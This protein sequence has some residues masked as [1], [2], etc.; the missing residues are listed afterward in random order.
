MNRI[1]RENGS[2]A[3]GDVAMTATTRPK[4]VGKP[5]QRLEDPRLLAGTG[6]YTADIK[7]DRMVHAA[8]LRS[9]NAH[10]RIV[11]IDCEA[12]RAMPGVIGVHTAADFSEI[13]ALTAPSRMRDYH[14]TSCTVLAREKVRYVG[15]P[16]AVVVARD[17]YVAEDALGLIEVEWEPLDVAAD[18]RDAVR[19]DAP[20]LHEELGTN[21]LFERTFADGEPDAAMARAAHTVSARFRMHRKS[22]LAMEPRAY[23][24]APD[25]ASGGLTLYGS[26][27]V[28]G[29]VRDCLAS[30]LGMAGS[31]LRVI[32]PDVGGGFGGK[33]SVYPE[34]IAVCALARRLDRPV[35]WVSDRGEDLASTSQGFDEI[36]EAELGFGDDGALVALRADVIGDVGAYSI[37]PWTAALEP[38]Q[39]VSFLPGPY[40]LGNYRGRVRGVATP[41]PPTGPYRGVGR[42]ASTFVMERLIDMAAGKLGMDPVEMRRRNLV[43]EE[44]F[45]YRAGSGIVWERSGFIECLDEACRS[46][47]YEALRRRQR[48]ARAQGRWFGI[49]IATYAELTGIG[50]RISVAPGMPINTGTETATVRIDSTG[51]VT[52]TFAVASHGQSLETTLAQVVAEELGVKPRDVRILQGD[53]ALSAHGTGTYASRSA[54]IGGGAAIKTARALREK[55]RRVASHLLEAAP[56][57]IETGDGRVFVAGTDRAISFAELAHA[58]YCDLRAL[59]AQARE[60]LEASE[61]FDPVTGTTTTSTHVAT[62]EIDPETLAVRLGDYHVAEDCGR[63]I[64]PIVVDGQVH[65]GVAQGVGAALLEELNYDRTGQL[66]TGSLADY[67]VPTAVEVP[68]MHVA[69]L[70]T[71]LP[72]NPGGFRGMGE[73]GTIGAPPPSPT[74]SA[75]RWRRWAS[76]STNCR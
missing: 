7:L 4:Y 27:Q 42:P 17:R 70:E 74:P 31:A 57:D 3:G 59:P 37:Y 33:G 19:D 73:G 55:V 15:E 23:L 49:G 20:V 76:V 47:G 6:R 18:A 39:V 5:V 28:P 65:G 67:A 60:T 75:T 72:A 10:A 36:I 1:A 16:L 32:A 54:V 13:P 43:R 9:E 11:S 50:S 12:A 44:E 22:P 21:V 61:T 29:I 30:L 2:A 25:R 34:E 69:H 62:V 40:R 46:A 52:A 45:P 51:A 35:K 56:E 58:V 68:R 38:V 53:S 71:E 63:M 66:L 8:F 41:K 14:A 26:T 24:A 64:N 48:E